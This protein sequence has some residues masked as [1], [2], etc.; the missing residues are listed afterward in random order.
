MI[1]KAIVATLIL[2]AV[3]AAAVFTPTEKVASAAG[4]L[5]APDG[6]TLVMR[7]GSYA[8][9]WGQVVGNNGYR[10]EI[11]GETTDTAANV[12]GL[13]AD[14][15]SV[16][17]VH[18]VR[19]KALSSDGLS[20]S[21]YSAMKD[22]VKS[23]KLSAPANI[24][25]QSNVLSWTAVA[26]AS[27]YKV[28]INGVIV[29]AA[30]TET[31]IDLSTRLYS[32]G[33][34]TIK[35]KAQGDN[36]LFLDSDYSAV[37]T[38]THKKTLATPANLAVTASDSKVT[39]SWDKVPYAAAYEVYVDGTTYETAECNYDV[40]TLVSAVTDHT[41]KVRAKTNGN[42][43]ASD[44]CTAATY[45]TTAEIANPA[46]SIAEGVA[47]WDKPVGADRFAVLVESVD[48]EVYKNAEYDGTS[49]D[50]VA[51]TAAKPA[52]EYRVS[53]QALANGNY[54]ASDIVSA[55]YVKYVKLS[56]PALSLSGTTVSWSA[57]QN[58]VNYTVKIDGRTL[59]CNLDA[60][61]YDFSAAIAEIKEY[62]ITVFANGGGW[63]LSS[64]E[65]SVKYAYSGK[66]SKT[67]LTVDGTTAS[68]TAVL[69][70]KTYAVTVDGV[71]VADNLT[72]TTFDLVNYCNEEKSY[73]IGVY[74]EA[75]DGYSA[76]DIVTTTITLSDTSPVNVE[77][78]TYRITT[79]VS[80]I[81]NYIVYIDGEKS[82]K[83]FAHS[84]SVATIQLPATAKKLIIVPQA[85]AVDVNTWLFAEIDL[86]SAVKQ[87]DDIY[88]IC[89]ANSC[90]V[91]TCELTEGTV[92][93]ELSFIEVADVKYYYL[94]KTGG[95]VPI[96][97]G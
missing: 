33:D 56:A 80:E 21:D 88:A 52:G 63:Y 39:A 15:L 74:A 47:T 71:K 42:F 58:A 22:V 46:L 53:V 77:E 97:A 30:A 8:L 78:K 50:L 59:A 17:E 10:V 61:S 91:L 49:L 12:N 24:G 82:D 45:A 54:S 67:D 29:A 16:G 64:D 94:I 40:T 89:G 19:V 34:Y 90:Q 5:T 81:Q 3:L 92:A 26:N 14:N 87:E 73:V 44:Y 6:I 69:G 57:V 11:D 18:K 55:S 20:D 32:T 83:R 72:T 2:F 37:Y 51:L 23:G 68:W 48:G 38:Y 4:K 31:T 35:I 85:D 79:G 62:T 86:T 93:E 65:A 75:T 41:V 25:V 70:A 95:V 96:T 84:G 9:S 36:L 1:K 60:V 76:A 13:N 28:T 66:L 7:N 27:S 43:S